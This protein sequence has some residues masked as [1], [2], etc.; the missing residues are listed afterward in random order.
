M[1]V[2][3]IRKKL[4]DYL[5]VAPDKKVKAI[6]TMIETELSNTIDY[7]Q[8]FKQE[9]DNR[10]QSYLNGEATMYSSNESKSRIEKVLADVSK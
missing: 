10:N 4:H 2:S 5:E 6:Y 3:T 7:S 1:D 9:L 8:E